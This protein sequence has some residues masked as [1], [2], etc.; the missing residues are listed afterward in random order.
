MLRFPGSIRIKRGRIHVLAAS[1]SAVLHVLFDEIKNLLTGVRFIVQTVRR[2]IHLA[3]KLRVEVKVR[4]II[5][6]PALNGAVPCLDVFIG[7]IGVLR[8]VDRCHGNIVGRRAARL[9]FRRLLVDE[10]RIVRCLER[11]FDVIHAHHDDD[12]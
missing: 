10:F 6:Q 1:G 11:V 9:P 7:F 5:G 3:C 8:L 4:H 12:G 2:R